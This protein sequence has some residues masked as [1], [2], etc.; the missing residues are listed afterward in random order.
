[1]E[2]IFALILTVAGEPD[3]QKVYKTQLGCEN[4]ITRAVTGGTAEA[5]FCHRIEVPLSKEN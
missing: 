5:G 4:A 3:Y 2:I 1:M